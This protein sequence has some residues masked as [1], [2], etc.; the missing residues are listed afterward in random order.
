MSVKRFS[1]SAAAVIGLLALP[2]LVSAACASGGPRARAAAPAPDLLQEGISLFQQGKYAA[3]EEAL[4]GASGAEA[5]AYLA[6]ALA[7]QRKYA[8]A[9]APA[10][11]AL[12][13]NPTH[14]VAVAALGESLVGQK[15]YDEADARLSAAIGARPDLAYAYFW[16]AQAYNGLK[17]ADRMVADYE[18]FLKLAPK[19]PEAP[20]VQQLLASFR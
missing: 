19:A 6:G 20:S 5:S 11:A 7:R 4:R 1:S 12:E 14:E 16:R 3:A 2:G 15:K 13:A 10:K 9:E 8:E 18:T 17:K